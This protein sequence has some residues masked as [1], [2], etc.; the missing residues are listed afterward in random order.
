MYPFTFFLS[1]SKLLENTVGGTMG[2]IYSILFE[3][4]ANTFGD[5]PGEDEICAEMWIQALE[6]ACSAIRK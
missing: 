1:L 6:N 3:A 4:A 2:C 5:Y